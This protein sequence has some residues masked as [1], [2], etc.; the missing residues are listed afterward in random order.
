MYQIIKNKKLI[1][2]STILFPGICACIFDLLITI[3]QQPAEYWKGD[4]EM[5]NEGN[6]IISILMKNNVAGIFVFTFLWLFLIAII[7]YFLPLKFL[8]PFSLFVLISHSW[9]A[10]S[11]L[12]LKYSFWH[13]IIFVLIILLIYFVTENIYTKQEHVLG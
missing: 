1:N 9:G 11:W 5:A 8:K 12:V 6:P 4:L 13:A 7:V 2:K 10:S 3:I